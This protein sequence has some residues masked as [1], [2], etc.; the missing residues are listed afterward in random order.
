MPKRIRDY[1]KLRGRIKEILGSEA[2]YAELL[3]L[4]GPSISAK[5]NNQVQFNQDEI[6]IT[7]E[8]L[9]IKGEEILDYFF[10]NKVENNST[11]K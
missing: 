8:L 2:K 4:S 5:L 3:G 6:D 1:S 11:K 7:L 10:T 9:N